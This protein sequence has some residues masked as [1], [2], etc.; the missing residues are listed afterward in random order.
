[1][2]IDVKFFIFHFHKFDELEM[3]M[4][5]RELCRIVEMIVDFNRNIST[6]KF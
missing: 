2:F 5:L 6:W 4:N 1:M 3:V